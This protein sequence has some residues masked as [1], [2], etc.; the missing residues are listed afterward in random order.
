MSWML[1]EKEMT[2]TSQSTPPTSRRTR[3]LS[4]SKGISSSWSVLKTSLSS[5]SLASLPYHLG[6][7]TST[8]AS[9]ARWSAANKLK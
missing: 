5:A 3:I 9:I 2:L 8:P 1:V 7:V 4:F 6:F